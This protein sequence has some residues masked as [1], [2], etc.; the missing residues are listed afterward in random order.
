MA[1]M[2]YPIMLKLPMGKKEG[3]LT[4]DDHGDGTFSGTFTILGSTADLQNCKVDE[5]G[6]YTA[7]GELT[8]I[9]GTTDMQ[10]EWRIVDGK[11][12]GQ[13]KNRMGRSFMKDLS[14]W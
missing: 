8:T 10:L 9:L 6:L 4:I 5:D 7:D 13:G 12:D 1:A 11:I 3:E 2:T 14:L